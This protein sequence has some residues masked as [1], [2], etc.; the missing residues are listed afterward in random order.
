VR[1]SLYEEFLS[2]Q[3]D[4]EEAAMNMGTTEKTTEDAVMREL[5]RDP[6]VCAAHIG[7]TARDGAIVLTGNVSTHA[8]PLAA[9]IAAE[10]VYGV[11]SVANEIEVRLRGASMGQ[12]A[13]IAEAISRQ[14]HWNTLVP[15]TVEAEVQKGFVTL[16]GTVE[17]SYQR[18]E[19]E[20][21]INLIQGVY[22]VT[23]LITIEPSAK[24]G[25][26]DIEH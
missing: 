22:G 10:R 9:V 19:A 17:W 2:R 1:S 13:D 6:K 16:R 14:L 23:N 7:V 26:T 25:P 12:D 21:P 8:E 11:R 3:H 5:E 18:D 15:E 20:R 24:P 4:L